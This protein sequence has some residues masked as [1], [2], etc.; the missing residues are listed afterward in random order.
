MDSTR[1][2]RTLQPTKLFFVKQEMNLIDLITCLIYKSTFHFCPCQSH[3]PWHPWITFSTCVLWLYFSFKFH[4]LHLVLYMASDFTPHY[5]PSVGLRQRKLLKNTT[6][7]KK[8]TTAERIMSQSSQTLERLGKGFWP[9]SDETA[10][11]TGML[12]KTAQFQLLDTMVPS[13]KVQ[14]RWEPFLLMRSQWT[15]SWLEGRSGGGGSC[16]PCKRFQPFGS[17][18]K[19]WG[20]AQTQSNLPFLS[21]AMLPGISRGCASVTCSH[22]SA[23]SSAWDQN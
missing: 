6:K 18:S 5:S 20:K 21:S 12:P 3:C 7:G 14:R 22:C 8:T 16:R 4:D 1:I 10:L 15:G 23:Q 19:D 13:L 11:M 9:D 2:L 17:G